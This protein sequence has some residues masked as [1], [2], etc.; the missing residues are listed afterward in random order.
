MP[1][2]P[3]PVTPK[4]GIPYSVGKSRSGFAILLAAGTDGT[5]THP[6]LMERGSILEFRGIPA[7]LQEGHT[8]SP[9]HTGQLTI[10]FVEKKPRWSVIFDN[11]GA[12][13]LSDFLNQPGVEVFVVCTPDT[14]P[15]K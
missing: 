15:Q 13:S 10:S 9:T 5:P 7:D 12:I 4:T 1:E 2:F 11:A 3:E 6:V 14:S 8:L